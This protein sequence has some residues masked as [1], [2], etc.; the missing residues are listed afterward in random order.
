[1]TSKNKIVSIAT[2]AAMLSA[3]LL[4]VVS[5]AMTKPVNSAA[6]CTKAT[7]L[8]TEFGQRAL[9][10]QSKTEKN[11]E[12]KNAELQKKQEQKAA[13]LSQNRADADEKRLANVAKL[14]GRAKTD[15]RKQAIAAYQAEMAA[16]VTTRR[17][18]VDAAISAFQSGV[19][20]AVSSHQSGIAGAQGAFATAIATAAQNAR[21]ACASGTN[22]KAVRTA[23][24]DAA[25]TAKAQYKATIGADSLNGQIKTLRD[26]ERSAIDAAISVFKSSAQAA[27]TAL[28]AAFN[29]K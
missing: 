5:F 13:A 26:T 28:Q 16:A 3:A 19:Q 10:L 25:K 7:S 4:P 20:S 9:D 27:R 29:Q 11:Q 22:L 12:N 24:Q 6:A 15:A 1:M 21:S 8:G 2:G 17:A 23:L 18:A 14:Q